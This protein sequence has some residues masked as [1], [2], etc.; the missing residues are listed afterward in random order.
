MSDLIHI[1]DAEFRFAAGFIYERFGIRLTD[2]KR[3]LVAGRLS[4]RL[5]KLGIASFSE[6]FE[7]VRR[8]S[9]GTEVSELLNLITTN[10]SFFFREGDH[11]E[12]L[13]SVVLPRVRDSMKSER[14]YPLR[15]WSAGCAAGEEA[16]T[17]AM[18]VREFF[19]N[20]TDRLD[21]GILATDISMAAL[22]GATKAEYDEA[23][24]HEMPHYYRT[25]YMEDLGDR[26]YGVA[27]EIRKMVLFKKLN[28]MS[29]R[30][31][32][33][34]AFDVIFCRN[35]MIY[36]DTASREQLVNSLHS[37]TKPG[38]NLFIGHSE[39]LRRETCPY[40]YISPAVYSRAEE[41]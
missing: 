5:R 23:K 22:A 41:R 34:H 14:G 12:Y 7:L 39:S 8:D 27:P 1:G 11:F 18:L 35:V 9:S 13:S 28:L 16:Y 20:E 4:K 29:E 31:P 37:V 30:L 19:G 6:Y 32:L 40:S 3:I 38:G 15:I 2:E 10:H 21:I 33:R 36:F 25:R 17:I 24:L 26:K